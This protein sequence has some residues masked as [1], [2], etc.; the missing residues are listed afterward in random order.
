[1]VQPEKA[2]AVPDASQ[3]HSFPVQEIMANRAALLGE[4]WMNDLSLF[5]LRKSVTWGTRKVPDGRLLLHG[6]VISCYC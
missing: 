2:I 6:L 5:A 3:Q 4:A 1:M